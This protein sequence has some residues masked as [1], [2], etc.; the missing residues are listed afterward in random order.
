MAKDELMDRH[1]FF[2]KLEWDARRFLQWYDYKHKSNQAL[3]PK[4]TSLMDWWK[5][6]EEWI[7]A[8]K[9]SAPKEEK[10][11]EEAA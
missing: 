8:D 10:K 7:A 9:P 1:G 2:M 5:R 3:Y 4:K 11:N 6:Y